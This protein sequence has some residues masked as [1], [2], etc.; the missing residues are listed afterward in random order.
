MAKKSYTELK[1]EIA[2]LEAQAER[3]R[4]SSFSKAVSQIRDL[5]EKNE[6]SVADLTEALADQGKKG[7]AAKAKS[8]QTRQKSERT[9]APV[10]P[11]Y[12][13]PTDPSVT[14]AGRGR[15]P[16]WVQAWIDAGNDLEKL[17]IR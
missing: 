17:L 5:M 7:K 2:K 12:Q 3:M 8:G 15:K 11:K 10:S 1:K 4:K 6:I 16:K 13:S 9:R 14:W